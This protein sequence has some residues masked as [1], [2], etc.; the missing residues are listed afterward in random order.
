MSDRERLLKALEENEDDT[1]TRL[2]FADWLDENGEH[3][4]A[5]RHRKWPKAKEWLVKFCEENN[6]H[7]DVEEEWIISYWDVVKLGREAA[8]ESNY[9]V[10]STRNNIDMRDALHT[11]SQEFWE[12]WSIVTGIPLPPK[13]EFKT[14][15]RCGC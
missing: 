6:P 14:G 11:N 8:N 1:T 13:G 9:W 4:E 15:F 2:I 5:D 10:F 12:N 7:E 3:E